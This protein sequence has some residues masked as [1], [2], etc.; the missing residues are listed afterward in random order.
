MSEPPIEERTFTDREVREILKRAVEDGP[1]EAL[2]SRRGLSLAELKSIG[3]EVGIDPARL[4]DAARA[5]TQND[6]PLSNPIVGVPIVVRYN[7]TVDGE[8]DATR[9]V[10]VLSVIR[11]IMGHHGEVSEVSGSLEWRTKG[12]AVDRL[13]SVSSHG[14]TTTIEASANLRQAAAS[15]FV[16][17]GGTALVIGLMGIS[18]SADLG[19]IALVVTSGFLATAYVGL[20]AILK[21]KFNS[22][23][24]KL[25]RVVNELAQLTRVPDHPGSDEIPKQ[26][27]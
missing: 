26:E 17:G 27:G 18:A 10:A 2:S 9:T 12:G 5:V 24:A 11:R 7:Q 8:L 15:T 3:R 23:S 21:K 4:E 16:S 19:P 25:E 13:V 20:R 22:E 1:T 14:R 6:E